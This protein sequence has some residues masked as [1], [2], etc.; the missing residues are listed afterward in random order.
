MLVS[1]RRGR[2]SGGGGGAGGPGGPGSRAVH[3]KSRDPSSILP[4]VS[5]VR[6]N[7]ACVTR[8]GSSMHGRGGSFTTRA[9]ISRNLDAKL[10]FPFD[11]AC[12]PVSQD[13]NPVFTDPLETGPELGMP[14][15]AYLLSASEGALT[16]ASSLSSKE[17]TP[18]NMPTMPTSPVS[19]KG[20]RIVFQRY[21]IALAFIPSLEL[22]RTSPNALKLGVLWSLIK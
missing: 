3:A 13:D 5:K 4:N 9:H 19:S 11:K 22:Q 17:T 1:R 15:K 18:P 12:F 2:G 20:K 7:F 10:V 14:S 6:N 16:L 8:G 21:R